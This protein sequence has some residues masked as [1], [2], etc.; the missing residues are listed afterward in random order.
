MAQAA[1]TPKT[2][3]SGTLM[4][5]TSSVSR[6][7]DSASGSVMAASATS[8]PLR[9]ACANTLASGT[10]RNS[11]MKPS[12]VPISSHCTQR[13]SVVARCGKGATA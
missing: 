10:K 1:E 9:S 5:A 2:R 8:R 12:A 13:A 6:I 3:F 11:V 7:A 4:A